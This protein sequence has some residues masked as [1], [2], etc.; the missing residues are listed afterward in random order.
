MKYAGQRLVSKRIDRAVKA[1]KRKRRPTASE[2]LRRAKLAKLRR[3][4]DAALGLVMRMRWDK[5]TGR[6]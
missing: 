1:A 5:E 2:L 3:E 6:A 4:R